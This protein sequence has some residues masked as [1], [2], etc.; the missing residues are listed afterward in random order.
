MKDIVQL[1]ITYKQEIVILVRVM[2]LYWI[3]SALVGAIPLPPDDAPHW[4]K[5]GVAF[6][7]ALAGNLTRSIIGARDSVITL[8]KTIRGGHHED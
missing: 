8:I 4:K 3:F 6:L 5:V 7:N 2:I 1:C